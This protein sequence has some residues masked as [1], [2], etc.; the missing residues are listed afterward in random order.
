MTVVEANDP[1]FGRLGTA[2]ANNQKD[3]I[4][5]LEGTTPIGSSDHPVAIISGNCHRDHF[6]EPFAITSADGATAHSACVA[7]GVDRITLALFWKHGLDV[8]KWPSEVAAT[9]WP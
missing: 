4:L 2:M 8:D 5:K 1:F 7:F 6:G 3:E 9:L